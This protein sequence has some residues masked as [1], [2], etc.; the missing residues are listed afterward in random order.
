MNSALEP[1]GY[2][3]A[4]LIHYGS[5][6]FRRV[7]WA[8]FA[9]G[10]ATFSLLYCVQALLPEF[11]RVFG[12]SEAASALSLSLSTFALAFGLLFAG[13]LS[14]IFGRRPVML[15]STF[16]SALLVLV[17]ALMPDWASFLVVRT[18]L[19]LTL[20]GLPAVAM[21]YLA[22]EVD[23]PSIGLG[24]GL[25]ISG[26]AIGGLSGRLVTG[27][28]VEHF[29]WRASMLVIA[30][31]GLSCTFAFW[32]LLPPSRH[33]VAQRVTPGAV[34]GHLRAIFRDAGLPWLFAEGFLLSGAFVTVY[35]FIGYRLLA[36]PYSLSQSAVAMVFVIYLTGIFGSPWV[37]DL[38]G[39][40]GRR[41]VLWALFVLVLL[42]VALTLSASLWLILSG[43]AVL[44]FS[45]FGAHSVASSWVGQRSGAAR[46]HATALYMFCYYLGASI[47]GVLG[48]VFM[49]ANGWAGVAG[50]VA[51]LAFTGLA[52]ALL[53]R[54][55]PP[56]P[57]AGADSLAPAASSALP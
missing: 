50:F 9:A 19:G 38:A 37:G 12:V 33:F 11:S 52:I 5:R 48:G 55:V 36:P 8:L 45:F 43:V 39:R 54:R 41:K 4:R 2:P 6:E 1:A 22:E 32:R 34:M 21:T 56:L 13:T 15:A 30:L 24:M 44:T 20:S 18:L 10:V 31:I 26:N 17:S 3:P 27:I 42:G 23:A 47:A 16:C 49:A 57:R 46:A 14:D 28:L 35:N 53:L 25:Y 29:D 51:A 7:N 40:L